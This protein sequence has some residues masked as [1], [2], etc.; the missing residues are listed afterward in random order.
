MV[1]CA[2]APSNVP[3]R[4]DTTTAQKNTA[5]DGGEEGLGVQERFEGGANS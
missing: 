1:R 2:Y 4:G 5:D 3:A